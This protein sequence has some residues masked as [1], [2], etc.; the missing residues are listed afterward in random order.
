MPAF[1]PAFV[2]LV[3]WQDLRSALIRAICVVG[4][5]G[6]RLRTCGC[7][8]CAP[9]ARLASHPAERGRTDRRTSS[10]T[11][12]RSDGMGEDTIALNRRARHEFTIEDTFEAGLV[13]TG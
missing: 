4:R 2:R 13:L 9:P 5:C 10:R 12:I 8:R 6:A 7:A 11:T 1:G 3:P